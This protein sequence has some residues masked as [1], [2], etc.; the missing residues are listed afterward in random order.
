MKLTNKLSRSLSKVEDAAIREAVALL[1]VAFSNQMFSVTVNADKN[2]D[3][4]VF[5]VSF[6]FDMRTE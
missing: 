2:K 1:E 3:S 5:G 6:A 4:E